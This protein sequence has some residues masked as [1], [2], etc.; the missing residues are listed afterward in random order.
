MRSAERRRN[1]RLFF[2]IRLTWYC[3]RQ[4]ARRNAVAVIQREDSPLHEIIA[5]NLDRVR[6]RIA[7]ACARCGRQ[8][9]SVKLIAV[10]KYAPPGAITGLLELGVRELGENRV[11]QLSKRAAE[12]G[13]AGCGL[14]DAPRDSSLPNW[15]MIGHLQRNKV[16]DLLKVCRIVQS[17]DSIRLARALDADAEECGAQV[18]VLVEVNL[19]GEIAKTGLAPAEVEP[20]IEQ[21]HDTP[22]LRLAGLMT[23]AALTPDPAASRGTFAALRTLL[24]ML[25]DRRMVPASCDQLSMGMSHDLEYAIEEG[26]T[27][28]RIGSSLFENMPDAKPGAR[29]G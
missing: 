25:R 3:P 16:R 14:R 19:S 13:S 24:E 18:D 1:A 20:L 15:H 9:E 23:M 4:G 7:A 8:S 26:A 10:T 11:Q 2:S 28:I 27:I 12:F 5:R 22:R 6:E 21:L 17:L 29:A